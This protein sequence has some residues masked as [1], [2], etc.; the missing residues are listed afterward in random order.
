MIRYLLV[1]FLLISSSACS[2]QKLQ[3]KYREKATDYPL[4]YPVSIQTID[5]YDSETGYL[6]YY[7]EQQAPYQ[8]VVCFIHGYGAINPAIYGKWIKHLVGLGAVVIYPRYQKTTHRPRPGEF[9]ETMSQGVRDGLQELERRDGLISEAPEVYYFGHSYGGAA[10]LYFGIEYEKYG[11][12]KPTA[13][14]AC[15]PG[16]GIYSAL[17]KPSYAAMEKD[18]DLVVL[19]SENDGVVG[20]KMAALAYQTAP[21]TR[22]QWIQQREW[23]TDSLQFKATHGSPCSVDLELDQPVYNFVYRLTLRKARYDW[24]DTEGY[25]KISEA[26]LKAPRDRDWALPKEGFLF[27]SKTLD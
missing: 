12:P 13:I 5:A 2:I 16:T 18:I 3:S 1:L 9:A 19:S 10:S 27:Y 22:K 20:D 23:S 24:E 8:K 14:F 7:D 21:V 11:L 6:I 15:Q 26:L 25:F 4:E 17:K